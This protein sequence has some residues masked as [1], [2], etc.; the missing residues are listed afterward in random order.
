M[1]NPMLHQDNWVLDNLTN[2]EYAD[3]IRE[4]LKTGDMCKT[5]GADM[6]KY[7]KERKGEKDSEGRERMAFF[8]EKLTQSRSQIAEGTKMLVVG[9]GIALKALLSDGVK[10]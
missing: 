6:R 1:S 4:G 5:F 7:S 3:R 10:E 9:H 2:Q 8:K